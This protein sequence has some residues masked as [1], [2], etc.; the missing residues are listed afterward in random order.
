MEEIRLIRG[1]MHTMFVQ[2]ISPLPFFQGRK[3]C[4]HLIV[5]LI[6]DA[7]SIN[8]L[9]LTFHLKALI[10]CQKSREIVKKQL[11]NSLC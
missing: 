1:E 4:N 11:L 9:S 8:I 6:V 5:N 10:Q 3:S 7:E 2:L